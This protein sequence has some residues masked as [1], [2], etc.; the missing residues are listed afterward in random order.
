MGVVGT[1]EEGRFACPSERIVSAA[2]N[3]DAFSKIPPSRQS[4]E[5]HRRPPADASLGREE[6]A[7]RV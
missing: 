2:L 4:L 1:E 3:S 5:Q 6:T 7:R